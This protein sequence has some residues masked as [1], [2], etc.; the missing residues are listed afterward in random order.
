MRGLAQGCALSPL[1]TNLVLVH[2]DDSL[3]NDGFSVVRCADDIAVVTESVADAWEA[4]RIASKAV[5][6]LGM[7]LGADKTVVTSFDEGFTFLGEDFGPR[8]PP[9]LDQSVQEPGTQGPLRRPPR[10]PGQGP[11][12]TGPGRVGR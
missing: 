5:E 7:S 6:E 9:V 10:R 4:A 3:L 8:Y 2:V 12:G 11:R 1:L